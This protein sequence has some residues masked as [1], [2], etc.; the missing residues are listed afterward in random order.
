MDKGIIHLV[1]DDPTVRTTLNRLLVSGGYRVR[2]YVSGV[3]LIAAA[4]QLVEGCILL[5]IN[6]PDT[7]GFAVKKALT[8]RGIELPVVMMTGSGDLTLLAWKAGV[9]AFVPKPFGR[10]EIISVLDEITTGQFVATAP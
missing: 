7:D 8:E 9:A 4:D 5:D 10:K 3:E 1:D 2:E 6:M